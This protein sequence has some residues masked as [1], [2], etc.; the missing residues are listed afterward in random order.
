MHRGNSFKKSIPFDTASNALT[1][2]TALSS[3]AYHAFTAT[4]EAFKAAFFRNKTVLQVPGLQAPREAAELDPSK[5]VTVENINLRQKKREANL[6]DSAV[7]EDNEM[8][9]TS[10]VPPDPQEVTKPAAPDETICC[11]PLTFDPNVK[12]S[13]AKDTSLATPVNQAELMH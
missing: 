12:A 10:N 6:S 9:K 2:Y 13:D 5:F 4:Y 11:G 7:T 3:K 8:V 1:F